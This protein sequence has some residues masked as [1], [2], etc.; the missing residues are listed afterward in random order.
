MTRFIITSLI[1]IFAVHQYAQANSDDHVGDIDNKIDGYQQGNADGISAG[2]V[3][4]PY[5]NSDCPVGHSTAYCLGWTGGYETGFNAQKT[6][7][8]SNR[9]ND[10]ENSDNDDK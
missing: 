9:Q 2:L 6:D 7:D 10:N 8:E 1:L 4:Y 5:R 3:D